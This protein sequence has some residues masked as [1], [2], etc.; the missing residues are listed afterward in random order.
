VRGAGARLGGGVRRELFSSSA[1][2]R[3]CISR[4]FTVGPRSMTRG[5]GRPPALRAFLQARVQLP[6]NFEVDG[7][8]AFRADR[9]CGC[10]MRRG[11]FIHA[12]T[13]EGLDVHGGPRVP[14]TLGLNPDYR[15]NSRCIRGSAKVRSRAAAIV[16]L[17]LA[18]RRYRGRRCSGRSFGAYCDRR[19]PGHTC[20]RSPPF[21]RS[22]LRRL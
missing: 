12:G 5:A 20:V 19:A 11:L 14:G 22:R 3:R 18:S 7:A 9:H 16:L 4:E 17:L 8:R 10:C 13:P 15:V 6:R 21:R 2:L 1:W